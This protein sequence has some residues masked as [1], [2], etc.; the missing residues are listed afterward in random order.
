MW[1]KW[2]STC[3]FIFKML[4]GYWRSNFFFF[5][6][7]S[8]GYVWTTVFYILDVCFCADKEQ[9][10]SW[11]LKSVTFKWHRLAWSWNLNSWHVHCWFYHSEFSF[12]LTTKFWIKSRLLYTDSQQHQDTEFRLYVINNFLDFKSLTK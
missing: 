9:N 1:S 12:E 10:L 3:S 11:D 6:C 8:T 5:M 2:K 7:R 4:R